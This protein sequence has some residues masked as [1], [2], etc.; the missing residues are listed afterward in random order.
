[1]RFYRFLR[2]GKNERL[3]IA[4]TCRVDKGYR[5]NANKLHDEF[6][7]RCGKIVVSIGQRKV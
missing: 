2:T 1:M 7:I 3:I 6:E 5:V 4:K